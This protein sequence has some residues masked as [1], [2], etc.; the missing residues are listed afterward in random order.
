MLKWKRWKPGSIYSYLLQHT[1]STSNH[2]FMNIPLRHMHVMFALGRNI[3]K[4]P[5]KRSLTG[6]LYGRNHP[7]SAPED[8][9]YSL[10]RTRKRNNLLYNTTCR[11]GWR[12]VI[13]GDK[14]GGVRDELTWCKWPAFVC[15]QLVL[16]LLLSPGIQARRSEARALISLPTCGNMHGT[17]HCLVPVL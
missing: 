10:Y 7:E 15:F 14:T 12:Q 13:G 5:T 6:G 9:I 2:Y 16:W 4:T 8:Y 17:C 3:K 11:Q 1:V